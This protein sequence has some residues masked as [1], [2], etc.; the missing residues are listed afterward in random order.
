MIE[1]EKSALITLGCIISTF[2]MMFAIAGGMY[3]IGNVLI[4]WVWLTFDICVSF[5]GTLILI[6]FMIIIIILDR[7]EDRSE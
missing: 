1:S 5:S 3:L 6:I 4:G 7:K 2:I